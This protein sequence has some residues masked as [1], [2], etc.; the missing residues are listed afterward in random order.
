[1]THE[2]NNS[3]MVAEHNAAIKGLK[4]NLLDTEE[5]LKSAEEKTRDLEKQAEELK[6]QAEL[7]KVCMSSKQV[8]AL[9]SLSLQ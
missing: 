7:A 3:E 5:M 2:K 8:I 4:Q 6:K 9:L 1:M